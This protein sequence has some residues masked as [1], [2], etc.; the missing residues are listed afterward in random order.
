MGESHTK[1][2]STMWEHGGTQLG[3]RTHHLRASRRVGM[4]QVA[5][6]K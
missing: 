5:T 2:V 6:K 1:Q 4:E 3:T